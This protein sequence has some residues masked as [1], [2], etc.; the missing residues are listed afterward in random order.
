MADL[1]VRKLVLHKETIEP[2]GG[3]TSP[4]GPVTRV[5]GIAVVAN[6]HAGGFVEDLSDLF[7]FGERLMAEMT[8]LLPGPAVS[9]GKAAIVGTSGDLEHAHAMLHPMLG[10]AMREPIGGG[11]ALILAATVRDSSWRSSVRNRALIELIWVLEDLAEGPSILLELLRDLAEGKMPEDEMGSLGL[12]LLEHLYPQHVGADRIWDYVE[13]LWTAPPPTVKSWDGDKHGWVHRLLHRSAPED[14]RI[15]LETLVRR[16]HRLNKVLAQNNAEYFAERLLTRGLQLFGEE[17][18]PA[19]LYE[20]FELV[21]AFNDWPG[22]VLA[23]CE[24]VARKTHDEP[25]IVVASIYGWLH[26][27]RDIQLALVLE[28]LKR[29]AQFANCMH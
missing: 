22:L 11:T 18:E 13:Q 16:A 24:G 21:Q 19:E 7:E 1:G 26:S 14:L 5:A 27:H 28:G 8:P 3:S 20:W 9:Y 17:T 6:P 4:D 25:W 23:H 29:K 12:R 15:L 2:E 10:K